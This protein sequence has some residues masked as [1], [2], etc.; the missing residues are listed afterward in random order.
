MVNCT[1][2]V[3]QISRSRPGVFCDG[4]KN[5]FHAVCITK[6]A[7]II[8]LLNTIPGLSWKCSDCTKNCILLNSANLQNM[9]ESKLN[10]AVSSLKTEINLIKLDVCRSTEIEG[11]THP[12]K[13]SD[14]LKDKSQPVIL[15]RP[16]DNKQLHSQTKADILTN[17][18]PCEENVQLTKVVNAKDGGIIIACKNKDDNEKLKALARRKMSG[19]YN[20]KEI[21]GILQRIRIVGL[22]AS[23]SSDDLYNYLFACNT[24]LF[25]EESQCKILKIFPTKKNPNIFQAIIKVDRSV[26]GRALET[27][28]LF[29]AYDSCS[30]YDAFDIFRCFKCNSFGHSAN[31]CTNKRS[32]PICAENHELKDCKSNTKKCSNCLKLNDEN[33]PVDHA[34][35]EKIKCSAYTDALTRLAPKPDRI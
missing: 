23:Y 21:G 8:Q 27:G 33:V 31:K 11:P 1:L 6:T 34:V 13:Y 7:D 26:Y 30:V 32:C 19:G 9:M 12:L 24:N 35:W 18:N 14:V 22:S 2:C 20:V 28:N 25:H 3:N 17:I 4:C 15:I 5:G 16:K 29:V 10:D